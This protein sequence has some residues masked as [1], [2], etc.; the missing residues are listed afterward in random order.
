VLQ[1]RGINPFES[2]IGGLIL[3]NLAFSFLFSGISIGGH[4]GGL[5]AGAVVGFLFLQADKRRLPAQAA[6][7]GAVVLAV[8]VAG[9]AISVA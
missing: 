8:A 4:I 6:L 1:S 5:I 3:F 7:A 9:A 2:G